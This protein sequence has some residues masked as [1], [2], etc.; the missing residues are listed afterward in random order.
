MDEL[1][2]MENHPFWDTGWKQCITI[3]HILQV[4]KGGEDLR[5]YLKDLRRKKG[6]SQKEVASEIGM[7]QSYYSAIEN[8]L[9]Q[10]SM[11]ISVMIKFAEV[12]GVSLEYIVEQEKNLM[13]S[14][15]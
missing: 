3:C 11:S 10:N 9:R 7:C 6:K 13:E 4:G 8:G 5:A 2:S 1:S 15:E 12:F 14:R